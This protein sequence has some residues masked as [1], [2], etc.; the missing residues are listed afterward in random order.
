M[1]KFRQI[2]DLIDCHEESNALIAALN[3]NIF[4]LLDK[5][6]M[7]ASQV[8]DKAGSKLDGTGPLLNALAAMGALV[9]KG[10]KFFN[11]SE[12]YKHLCATSKDYKKGTVMLRREHRREWDKLID[13]IRNGRK[14]EEYEGPD[15]PEFRYLF[16][17]AMHERS[18][19]LAPEVVKFIGRKTVGKLLDLGSGPGS[20]SLALLKNDKKARAVLLDRPSALKVAGELA[21]SLKLSKRVDC[22]EGDLFNTPYGSGFDTVFYSNILHIYDEAQNQTILKKIHRALVPGGRLIVGDFFLSNDL[23]RPYEAALF[24]VTMLLF[25]AR[26]RTYTFDETERMLKKLGFHQFRRKILPEGN[27]LLE[28]VRK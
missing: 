19:R 25:T 5:K 20:Y 26:G 10:E 6:G 13:V 27:A 23:C 9:K 21:Q 16:S 4:T 1:L 11:T 2:I 17:W 3:L 18:E 14:L 28:A 22:I 15:D 7:T 12:T 24:S 8:A